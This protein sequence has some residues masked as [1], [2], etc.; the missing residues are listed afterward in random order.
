M[1]TF[2]NC[3]I[4]LGLS[5]L[6][7]REDGYH[8]VASLFYPVNWCDALEL[9]VADNFSFETAGLRVDGSQEHN[10]CVRA[11]R[12]LQKDF[13]L[14]PVKMM[15]LKNIPMGAGLGGGSADG[16]FT[17]TMLNERFQL[18]LTTAQL[19]SYAMQLGSDCPFF[20]EN[21]PM[22]VTG[23]GD[24]ME[25]ATV[26]LSG[27][28]V[29]IVYPDIVIN[30]AWAFGELSKSKPKKPH[31]DAVHHLKQLLSQGPDNWKDVLVN[32]FEKVVAD[33]YPEIALIIKQLYSSGAIYA[34]MSGSGSAVFGIFEEAPKAMDFNKNYRRYSGVC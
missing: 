19:K 21:K 24:I 20:I 22:L 27:Y 5:I 31:V 16:A 26:D 3:K 7:K 4:N 2:P 33:F 11:Y 8:N 13:F 34:A 12:L 32:D 1:L 6:D 10:L 28:A 9:I 29:E 18:G 23:K 14:P 25:R 17:I 30:T 15:L